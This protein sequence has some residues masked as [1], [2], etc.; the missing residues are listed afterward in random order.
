MK[1]IFLTI[2][3]SLPIA[4]SAQVGIGISTP[5]AKLDIGGDLR[6]RTLPDLSSTPN[7]RVLVAD[8]TQGYV[9]YAN[10]APGGDNWGTQVAVTSNPITG[11]GVPA[12]P[13][14]LINGTAP[15]QILIWNNT[16]QQWELG[17]Y[18]PTVNTSSPII[19]DGSQGNPIRLT[20]GNNADDMLLWDGNSWQINPFIGWKL[21]GNLG[22]NPANNFVG[23]LDNSDLA[24]RT[25][26]NEHVRIT[27]GGF[28]GIGTSTPI[29]KTHIQDGSFLVE[30]NAVLPGSG[31]QPIN[32]PTGIG[33]RFMW[34][35]NRAAFRMGTVDGNVWNPDSIGN[36]SFAAGY[37]VKASNT[38]SFV[39]GNTSQATG[40]GST[41]LGKFVSTIHDGS[42]QI[43]DSPNNNQIPNCILQSTREDQFSARFYGGYRFLT[44]YDFQTSDSN[45]V[46]IIPVAQ[47]FQYGART[48]FGTSAPQAK[49]HVVGD[50][51]VEDLGGNGNRM[52][53][54]NNSG[55]LGTAPLPNYTA[56]AGINISSGVI[57]VVPFG[58][59]DLTGNM[60]NPQVTKLQGKNLAIPGI[61]QD[62]S[63]LRWNQTLNRWEPFSGY[64]GTVIVKGS[65][66]NNCNLVYENGLLIST[67][68]P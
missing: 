17:V 32:I 39:V 13:I 50:M 29:V 57:S 35:H 44:R 11:T 33:T 19:G 31:L 14:R 51:I 18:S 52:V 16:T 10:I 63:L 37:N 60:P 6:I 28:V 43:G 66:G 36:L 54:V 61:I 25:N 8:P 4:L 9:G 58:G 46:Y 27:T 62:G 67:T 22:T 5:S 12:N 7:I 23:T 59:G 65:N 30:A 56:G 38:F 24:F 41:A 53:T 42:F 20:D 49:V 2:A 47:G 40:V 3:L 64:T 34:I 45:G 26:N 55:K 1:K 21:K 48:G 68:C 15:N